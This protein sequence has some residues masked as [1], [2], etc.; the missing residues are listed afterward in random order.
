MLRSP[1]FCFFIF[2]LF[3]SCE[4]KTN[5]LLKPNKNEKEAKAIQ[6]KATE[7]FQKSNYNSAFY[8]FN[9]SKITFENLKDSTNVVYNLIQMGYIQQIN[10]DYYGSK[11]TFTEALPFIKKK[12]IYSAAINNFF[13]IAD[14]ELSIYDDAIF[15]YNQAINDSKDVA[16]KQSPLN[17]IA[18]VY[19]KQKKYD[20]A[21]KILEGILETKAFDKF[22]KS[23]ARVI[24]NLGFAYFKKG[25]N[26]KGL[27]LMNESLEL[28]TKADDLYGS[29]ESHLHLAEFYSKINIQKSNENAKKAYEISTNLNSVDERLKA[30]SFL[31]S[32]GSGTKYAQQ[33][34]SIND[35][36]IKIRNNFKNKFAKIKYDSKKEKDENQ[37]LRLEKIENELSLQKVKYQRIF[38]II[39]IVSLFFLL[40][41]LRK[42][43]QNRNRIEK[44]KTAYDTETRIAKDIHDEL[45][46]DVF[47]TITFTQTQPLEIQNTKETLL[48]KLDHIYSRVRGISRENNDIDTG[49]N[50]SDNLK[51]MLSTYN[52]DNTNVIIT[53][54]EKVNWDSIEDLKKIA[55]Q[56]VLHELM[57]NMKKHSEAQL[58]VLKFENAQNTLL[59]DYKDNGKGCEKSKIIKNGLQ[60]MENRILAIK[61]TITFET[62]PD[63][64][65]KVNITMP[66]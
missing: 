62:E 27:Q 41:Y 21:V 25:L 26:E 28:R 16:S 30:L 66:K 44:I 65:F 45:A 42:F 7:Q 15:Y 57:V 5:V 50:Y 34:I 31:I 43:Y 60:N 59:I 37:K 53:N 9:K 61:G 6:Q 10:G 22:V 46:N 12:D 29:I 24:D 18:V 47:N 64:G 38:F 63:K 48:Q 51:E 54:I 36:I 52:S 11:E 33:Y 14:K 58:V 4:E 20:K 17:N 39:G 40:L 35:S 13:G 49:S 8:Y 55:I 56:R 19:I 2:F 23:K 3:L 1:F 32:N